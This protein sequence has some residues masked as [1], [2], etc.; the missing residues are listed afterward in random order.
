LKHDYPGNVRELENIIEHAFVLAG[1]RI[2]FDCL[3]KEITEGQ[4]GKSIY[5]SPRR[6]FERQRQKSSK[7]Y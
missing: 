1:E 3:P 5:A 4:K 6:D 7:G 2:D